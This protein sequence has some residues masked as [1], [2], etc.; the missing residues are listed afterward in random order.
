MG[1][2]TLV[3]DPQARKE[4]ITGF[5]KRK[6]ERRQKARQRIADEVRQERLEARREK[7]EQLKALR[8]IGLGDPLLDAAGGSQSRSTGRISDQSKVEPPGLSEDDDRIESATYDFDGMVATTVVSSLEPQPEPER[9]RRPRP[10]DKRGSS[11]PA[12]KE[13][14]FN[15]DVPLKAAIPG[16]K[17]PA[18]KKT[19]SKHKKDKKR[20]GP[21][22][23]KEKAKN[24]AASMAARRSETRGGRSAM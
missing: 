5:H 8:G 18:G 2:A 3:F 22:A 1:R 6:V 23:K 4:F 14:K 20:R 10:A 21:I 7:R 12:P 15:L 13:R 24:R 17:G 9:P 11:N 19:G 16:Y